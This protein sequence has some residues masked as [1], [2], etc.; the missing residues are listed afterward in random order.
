VQ[1][2]PDTSEKETAMLTHPTLLHDYM[3]ARVDEGLRRA[4]AAAGPREVRT[5]TR[6]WPLSATMSR[7]HRR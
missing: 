2:H 1:G 5:R 6:P 3:T 7:L 4:E